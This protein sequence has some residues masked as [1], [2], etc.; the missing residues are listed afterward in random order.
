MRR[1]PWPCSALSP[2]DEHDLRAMAAQTGVSVT[3][4][5]RS[6][7]RSHLSNE[8]ARLYGAEVGDPWAAGRGELEME[9]RRVAEGGPSYG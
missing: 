9:Q 5:V 6:A 3:T 8:H 7:I 1:L 2:L 4:F